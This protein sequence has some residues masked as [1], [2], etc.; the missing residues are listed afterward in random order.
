MKID[1]QT[2]E[3]GVWAASFLWLLLVHS[4]FD[5]EYHGC[6]RCMV[7]DTKGDCTIPLLIEMD[8]FPWMVEMC[9]FFFVWSI[10]IQ[11]NT[12]PYVEPLLQSP[13]IVM[14]EPMESNSRRGTRLNRFCDSVLVRDESCCDIRSKCQCQANPGIVIGSQGFFLINNAKPFTAIKQNVHH[15]HR[16]SLRPKTNTCQD[17]RSSILWCREA[18]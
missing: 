4:A 14:Y 2:L 18:G 9:R 1:F 3:Y 6:L 8:V 15:I 7:L 12:L 11:D 10:A 5:T 16:K 13:N 17:G